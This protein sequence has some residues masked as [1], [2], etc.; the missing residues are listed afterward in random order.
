M[1]RRAIW[2]FPTGI[3]PHMLSTLPDIL[4]GI[5][6]SAGIIGFHVNPGFAG[7]DIQLDIDFGFLKRQCDERY[8]VRRNRYGHHAGD[9]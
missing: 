1:M 6:A 7:I 5:V 3:I 8:G 4:I 9:W 2:I